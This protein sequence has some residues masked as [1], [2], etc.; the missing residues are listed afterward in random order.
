MTV[1]ARHRYRL[2]GL[3]VHEMPEN[4]PFGSPEMDNQMD[5]VQLRN[6]LKT[7]DTV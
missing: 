3:A 2:I 7:I 5:K 1:E 4:R 6:Y